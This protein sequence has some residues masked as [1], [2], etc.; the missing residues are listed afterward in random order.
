MLVGE[1]SGAI[2]IVLWQTDALRSWNLE[3]SEMNRTSEAETLH[4][5]PRFLLW[6]VVVIFFLLI[7][8]AL[9]G[10][11]YFSGGE[12]LLSVLPFVGISVAGLILAGVC[13]AGLL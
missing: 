10:F 1:A 4:A 9:A 2:F 12:R 13:R 3:M 8:G 7:V 5:P 6:L 11:S